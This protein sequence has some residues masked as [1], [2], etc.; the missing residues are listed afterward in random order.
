M[1]VSATACLKA[2]IFGIAF[3]A[4]VSGSRSANSSP[5]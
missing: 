5:P 3:S 4:S 1:G 2:S